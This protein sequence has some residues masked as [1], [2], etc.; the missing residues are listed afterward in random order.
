MGKYKNEFTAKCISYYLYLRKHSKI[1]LNMLYVML[2]SDIVINP[3]KQK[4]MNIQSLFEISER[5]QQGK[6]EVEAEEF[7]VIVLQQSINT[8]LVNF[9]VDKIHLLMSK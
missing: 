5:F 1:I 4:K 6:T 2:D 3:N 7:F 9:V 8:I